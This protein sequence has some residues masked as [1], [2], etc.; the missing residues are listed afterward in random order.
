[1]KK[2]EEMTREE[3]IEFSKHPILAE[4]NQI[5]FSNIMVVED[6]DEYIQERNLI[7]LSEVNK[8]LNY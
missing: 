7:D 6:I 3:R 2:Y 5:D 4:N 1:M 8:H